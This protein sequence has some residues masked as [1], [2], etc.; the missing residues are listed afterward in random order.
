MADKATLDQYRELCDQLRHHNYRY[1]ILDQPEVSDAEYDRLFRQLQELEAAHPELV[2]PDSP[3]QQVGAPPSTRFT[4][5]PHALPMLSLKNVRNA[6]EFVDFDQSLRQTFLGASSEIE[7]VCEM[8]LDGVAVEL[9]YEEG[10][11]QYASTRGDGLVGEEITAN[12]KTL[13]TIPWQLTPPFPP[14]LD[15][16]GEVYME[17]RDFQRLNRQQEEKGEKTFANPRNAAAGSLRQL[18][19]RV[20][21]QRPLKIFCYGIGRW[22]GERPATH[23]QLLERLAAC[24]LRVNLAET[25][26]ATGG[27][28][29]IAA[30]HALQ[31]RRDQLPYEID[32]MVVKVNALAL[33]EELGEISRSPRWA[34]ACKF[35][36]RQ[37]ETILE[38]VELQVGRTGAITPVAHLRPVE[39]SGVTVSRASLHNWDE[40]ERLGLQIS[41]HVIVERAGDV[42]PD[43]V[44]VV[45][46]KRSGKE[47]PIPFP[48]SCPECGVPVSRR[49]GEVVPRC[50]N[51]H[52]PARTIER[53]RHFVSRD[54]MDIE[55]LG[56][57]QLTELI[58]LGR[59]ETFSDL[60]RLK[61]DDFFALERM[62]EVLAEKLLDAIAASKKRPLSRFLFALGIRHVGEH[63]AKI[64]A[65]RFATIADL[66]AADREELKRIHEIGDKVADSLTDFFRNPQQLQLLAELQAVGVDPQPEVTV[67][68]DGSLTGRTLVITG[69]LSRWS[70][71]E[72]EALVESRGG[73]VAGSV[74]SKTSYVIAGSDAGSKLDKAHRLAIPVLDEEAFL[75]L[76]EEGKTDGAG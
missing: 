56:E 72:A 3:S 6:G 43:I 49:D 4:P 48:A 58:G 46:E 64:L 19:P 44:A 62:G 75:R 17:L 65:K 20:T 50:G 26:L 51:A 39:V 18:D 1:Y 16:R 66:A 27:E 11:L 21:A 2:T 52:C 45:K 29:V 34:V 25:S 47:T 24:G 10:R 63:T 31:Q 37:R 40:I 60:Y 14:L 32:G 67:D 22:Q 35:P 69:T 68:R 8:K 61:K 54:A 38:K 70:R 5:I 33:Q 55:G 53:L 12:L 59:L 36:P 41:D 30:F 9:V 15:V 23:R 74:S 42:I 7:Y 13:A 71:T 57:K 76:L 73:R 28:A